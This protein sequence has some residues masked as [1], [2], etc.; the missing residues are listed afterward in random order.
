MWVVRS[1]SDVHAGKDVNV[2]ENEVTGMGVKSI[3]WVAVK[4]TRSMVRCSEWDMSGVG[5]C[6][7]SKE[8]KINDVIKLTAQVPKAGVQCCSWWPRC[9][10]DG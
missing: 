2:M 8:T 10:V 9:H 6:K 5:P 7:R 4:N 3:S 1:F